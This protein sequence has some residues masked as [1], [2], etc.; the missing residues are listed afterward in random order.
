MEN[1]SQAQLAILEFQPLPSSD[2]TFLIHFKQRQLACNCRGPRQR[3]R[4]QDL[5]PANFPQISRSHHPA[6]WA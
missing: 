5:F 2:R 4:F 6:L 3:P 1:S